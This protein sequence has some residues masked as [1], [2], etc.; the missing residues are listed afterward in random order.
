M[1]A[2]SLNCQG[3]V[4]IEQAKITKPGLHRSMV[5]PAKSTLQHPKQPKFWC[6]TRPYTS[7]VGKAFNTTKLSYRNI[8]AMGSVISTSSNPLRKRPFNQKTAHSVPLI[9]ILRSLKLT[10][11]HVKT[12]IYELSV[13]GTKVS[14][15]VSCA[16]S[17]AFFDYIPIFIIYIPEKTSWRREFQLPKDVTS[18]RSTHFDPVV[19]SRVFQE[20]RLSEKFKS[21]N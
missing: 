14:S 4:E 8:V 12:L 9:D 18:I 5:K 6:D 17:N 20:Q 19:T 2:K 21:T 16:S 3:I 1:R 7:Y 13:L 11:T 15:F 10:N